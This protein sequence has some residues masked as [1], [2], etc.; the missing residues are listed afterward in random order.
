M[1]QSARATPSS[2]LVPVLLVLAA[3]VS[4]QTGASLAKGLFPVVGTP[5]TVAL[6]LGLGATILCVV[7]R[8]W[9]LF[10]NGGVPRATL[11]AVAVYGASLGVMNLTFY[12]SLRTVPLGI[13]VALE[14]VGPLAVALAGARRMLDVLWVV[15]AVAGLLLLLPL[16]GLESGVDPVGAGYALTAGLFW[17]VYILFGKKA[18]TDLGTRGSALGVALAAVLVVPVGVIDAGSALLSPAVLL[19]GLAVAVLSTALP[20][21]LE[22]SA[23]SRLPS[24]T[25]STLMSAEPAIAALCGLVLLGENLSLLQWLAIAAV[26]AASTGATA[27]IRPEPAA[28]TPD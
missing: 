25:F 1:S 26:I 11:R 19:P 24:A 18:G 4:L 3:M 8:P 5:G 20:Y 10:A 17:A 6:R 21:T 28:P 9:R 13:S 23:L 22:I 2:V 27:T 16:D 12:L 15:L 14:F 7:L